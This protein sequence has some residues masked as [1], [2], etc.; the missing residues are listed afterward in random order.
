MAVATYSHYEKMHRQCALE[1][2]CTSLIYVHSKSKVTENIYNVQEW[3]QN[4]K[5][6]ISHETFTI[7]KK[8]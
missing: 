8:N 4:T 6:T 5:T 1:L 2:Y 7:G 3:Y